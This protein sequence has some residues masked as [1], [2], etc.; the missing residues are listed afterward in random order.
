MGPEIRPPSGPTSTRSK[1]L[2]SARDAY[3]MFPAWNS[4]S[5]ASCLILIALATWI[6]A[7]GGE[8]AFAAALATTGIVKGVH[9]ALDVAWMRYFSDRSQVLVLLDSPER[10]EYF[11]AS[12]STMVAVPATVLGLV[13]AFGSA[14]KSTATQAGIV[15]LVVAIVAGV[16]VVSLL[17]HVLTG[18]L[19]PIRFLWGIGLYAL[20]FGLSAIGYDLAFS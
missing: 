14:T 15:A 20:V 13:A 5:L 11:H 10:M 16:L 4:V 7:S 2:V 12:Q 8:G 18:Y 6:V 17:H 3:L 19:N 9:T 1:P